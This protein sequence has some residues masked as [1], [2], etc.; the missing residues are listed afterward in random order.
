M[1]EESKATARQRRLRVW[2]S[3]QPRLRI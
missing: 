2:Q 1:P 3:G